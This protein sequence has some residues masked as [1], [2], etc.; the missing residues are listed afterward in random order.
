M[1]QFPNQPG[2]THSPVAVV[3]LGGG[4]GGGATGPTG[5]AGVGAT[6]ATGAGATGP[7]GPAGTGATGAT[8]AGSTGPT[9]PA[10]TG[11][12]GATGA[13]A[14]GA[15]GTAGATGP[16]GGATGPT[17]PS[18]G[19]GSTG[20]TG[21]GAGGATGPTG[22]TGTHATANNANNISGT[23]AP[24]GTPTFAASAF[25]TVTGKVLVQAQMSCDLIGGGTATAPGNMNFQLLRDGTPIATARV[26]ITSQASGVGAF[27]SITTIDSPSIAAHTYSLVG[28]VAVAGTISV[29]TGNAQ[30]NIIDL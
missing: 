13:G 20:A 11:A 17:G 25:T 24:S 10:G 15:T 7:T 1:R 3:H 9:G 2:Y 19:V 29:Q 28:T 18:G 27:V 12:T 4:A 5:P 6:G 21:A 22:P 26:S 23:I 8:G 16:G 14:T 30:I